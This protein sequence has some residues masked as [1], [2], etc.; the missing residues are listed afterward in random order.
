MKYQFD[1]LVLSSF[2]EF[3]N[4]R[5]LTTGEAFRNVTSNFYY[6]NGNINGYYVYAA[7]YQPMVY[8]S[9]I[10][11]A[12]IP[13]G[14]Y[15]NNVFVTP[16]TSGFIGFNYE[17][18]QAIFSN[19]INGT[20]RADYAVAD[21]SLKFTTDPEQKILFENKYSLQPRV[22]QTVT[23]LFNNQSSF[24]VLYIKTNGSINEAFSFGGTNETQI[25][26]RI[27][28][29]A[30]SQFLLDA[31]SSILRD[32]RYVSFPLL[33]TGELPFDQLGTYLTGGFNYNVVQSNHPHPEIYIEDCYVNKINQNIQVEAEILPS[34]VFLGIAEFNLCI[35]RNP[36]LRI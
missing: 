25:D 26:I 34:E 20:V 2:K 17:K 22:N 1:N 4:N 5:I 33:T 3:I 6:V 14:V 19:Y 18:S 12:T 27:P 28:I 32:C 24:P 31:T 11:G 13:S 35:V 29:L 7:P 30:D 23:G 10:N 36:N 21:Y 16:G 15:V 8:D 9:S